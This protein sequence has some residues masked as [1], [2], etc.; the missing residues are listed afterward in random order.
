MT[1]LEEDDVRLASR[2]G[3]Q[4]PRGFCLQ[5]VPRSSKK[6]GSLDQDSF[7]DSYTASVKRATLFLVGRIAA[8]DN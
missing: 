8:R 2:S 6:V 4:R 7:R 1:E 5:T 3:V